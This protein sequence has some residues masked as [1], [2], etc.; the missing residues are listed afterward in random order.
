MIGGHC[1]KDEAER[2]KINCFN[3]V[4][5]IKVKRYK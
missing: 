1:S 3:P 2:K 4:I 5:I